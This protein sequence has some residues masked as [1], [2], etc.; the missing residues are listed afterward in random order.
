ME[1]TNS[2]AHSP[3]DYSILGHPIL[4]MGTIYDYSFWISTQFAFLLHFPAM[5]DTE[6]SQAAQMEHQER[7]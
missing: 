4:K 5:Q 3:G 1:K 6:V 7:C 2:G